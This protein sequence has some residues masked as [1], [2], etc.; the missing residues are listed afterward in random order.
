MRGRQWTMR[1][2]SVVLAVSCVAMGVAS[3]ATPAAAVAGPHCTFRGQTIP[4]LQGVAAGSKIPISCTGLPALNPYLILQ[5]SL[6]IGIDPKAEALLSGGSLGVGTFEGALAALPE[7]DATSFTPEVSDLS[8]DLSFTYTVPSIQATDPNA[9]CPPSQA[10]FN[11]GLI[12]CALAMVDLTTQKPVGAG[13]AVLEYTGFPLLP[14]NPTLA[15][16]AKKARS[17]QLVTV[18]DAPGATTYWWVATLVALEGLLAGGS[19]P[20]PTV[21]V[22]FGQHRVSVP[23]ANTISV[24]PAGYDGTTLTFPKISGSFTVPSGV[25]GKQ[26]VQVVVGA[27]LGGLGLSNTAEHP[28][29]VKG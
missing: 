2:V 5:A 10:E 19:A 6:L 27:S 7:I 4:L 12:G 18:S 9:T 1:L 13:S 8:G 26:K 14:P 17:G 3:T 20:A 15:F 24:A 23:A 21:T 25:S 11:A 29:T 22:N 16:S 28:L